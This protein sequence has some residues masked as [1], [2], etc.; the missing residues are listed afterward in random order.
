YD[1]G[2]V[3]DECKLGIDARL[4]KARDPLHTLRLILRGLLDAEM[5]RGI[6]SVV[7][8]SDRGVHAVPLLL[9]HGTITA[10]G[11]VVIR[12]ARLRVVEAHTEV[13]EVGSE[14]VCS[15]GHCHGSF[16]VGM[17]PPVGAP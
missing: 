10:S 2:L 12:N 6:Q 15:D 5:D 7:C 11:V 8:S 1:E 14:H 9:C 17:R 16:H 4:S 3:K 13:T